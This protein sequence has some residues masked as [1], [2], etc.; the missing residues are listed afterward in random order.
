LDPAAPADLES[1][2]FQGRLHGLARAQ[3]HPICCT[4]GDDRALANVKLC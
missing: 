4:L 3:N 1:F 2:C